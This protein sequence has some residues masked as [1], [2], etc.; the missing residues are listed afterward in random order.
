MEACVR[1]C[2]SVRACVYMRVRF[3][4]VEEN[5]TDE[6]E[7]KEGGGEKRRGRKKKKK[8]ES[9]TKRRRK[10]PIAAT[11]SNLPTNFHTLDENG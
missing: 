5:S 11:Q 4:G 10:S 1:A 6:G 9:C 3:N 8:K 2:V 7:G